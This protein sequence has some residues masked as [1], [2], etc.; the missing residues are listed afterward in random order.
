M[1]FRS[2]S[3]EELQS[4]G[5]EDGKTYQVEYLNRDYFN[6]D[7]TIEKSDAKAMFKDGEYMFVIIDPYGMD[8]IVKEVRVAI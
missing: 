3:Q 2:Q 5:L 6:G 8:K 1:S 4:L 7:V